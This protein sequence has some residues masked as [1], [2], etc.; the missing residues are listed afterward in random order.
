MVALLLDG[1]PVTLEPPQSAY[2]VGQLANA[3]REQLG[4]KYAACF[5]PDLAP[6]ESWSMEHLQ[7]EGKYSQSKY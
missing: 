2:T 5:G 7:A 4:A 3:V 6:Y 1:R